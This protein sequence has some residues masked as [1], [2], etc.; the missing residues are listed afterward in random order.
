MN[1]S[2]TSWFWL[3][4]L[5][6]C[7]GLDAHGKSPAPSPAGQVTYLKGWAQVKRGGQWTRIDKGS[8]LLWGDVVATGKK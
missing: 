8:A 7:L 2:V 1:R 5:P 3:V 6:L 4:L